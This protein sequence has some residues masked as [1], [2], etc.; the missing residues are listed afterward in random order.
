MGVVC[1]STVE[2]ASTATTS[3]FRIGLIMTTR[4]EE[5]SDTAAVGLRPIIEPLSSKALSSWGVAGGATYRLASR[6][7]GR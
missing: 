6:G 4:D 7:I 2:A 5:G 1:A 3:R